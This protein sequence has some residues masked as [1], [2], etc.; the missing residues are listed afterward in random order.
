MIRASLLALTLTALAASANADTSTGRAQRWWEDIRILASNPM[1][2]RLT[3]SPGYNRAA[4]FVI[5][6]FQG[7][8]LIPAGD[9]HTFL[10][11]VAF[12]TQ[13]IDQRASRAVLLAADGTQTP[14]QG[15]TD[16]LISAGGAPRAPRFDAPL[17]FAGY[18]LHLPRLGYDDFN[19]LDVRGKIVVVISGGPANL[20][21]PAKAAARS[22]RLAYL[23]KAG[24]A[25]LIT[26]TTPAQVE[27][28]W[29]R[30]KLLASQTGMF[31]ADPKL[32]DTPDGL[33]VASI[34]PARAGLLFQ[35]ESHSFDQLA[36]LADASAAVPTFAMRSRLQGETART[37]GHVS[38]PNL[39]A[40]LEGSDPVL[41]SQYV[42]VSA[43]LD[44]LGVGEPIK[45]DPIYHGA[46]DDASG[47]A[48]VL[49]IAH[50]LSR[51]PR[52]KRSILFVLFTG[53]EKGLLG[54][55]FF[56][57][58]PTVPKGSIVA[59]LN[60][61]M[62]LPLWPLH[63]VIVQGDQESTLGAVAQTVSIEQTLV[64]LPDPVPDR[65]SFTRTDQFS[66]VRAG[67][68]ALAFKFGFPKGSREFEIEHAWRA[69]R[70]HSPLDNIDQPGVMPAEAIKLDDYIGA[71]AVRVANDPTRP[72]W[73]ASSV[74][75]P[76]S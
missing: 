43:H 48:S 68:P 59:D 8:D 26:L 34:D 31:L 25:G 6:R 76:G 61:D 9:R 15:G 29:T 72:D 13:T 40:K 55:H 53:E 33:L 24:A 14:L 49:D 32:R 74:F 71:I 37:L 17:V 60:M 27:I 45:G 65:N 44:H 62:P 16:M 11:P 12:E 57:Q 2:G 64:I 19:G 20:P 35:G 50:A 23:A 21:G 46:M 28:P 5:E 75:K 22:E 73:L 66:F 7:E 18:G 52:P 69:T 63:T 47:V 54:S 41:K 3:G 1:Q 39:V 42:V 70:Y 56:A 4:A 51:G 58:R 30:L 38:S 10:Q 67:V 36:A